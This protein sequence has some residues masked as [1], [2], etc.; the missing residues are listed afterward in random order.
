MEKLKQSPWEKLKDVQIKPIEQECLDRVFEHLSK[1]HT[2]WFIDL[3]FC[4]VK[5]GKMSIRYGCKGWRVTL[6]IFKNVS[7]LTCV[8]QTTTRATATE[9]KLDQET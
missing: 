9:T 4:V 5:Q 1:F 3:A 7:Y 8:L 2:F 6:L